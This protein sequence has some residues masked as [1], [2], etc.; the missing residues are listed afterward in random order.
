MRE[1]KVAWSDL[2]RLLAYKASLLGPGLSKPCSHIPCSSCLGTDLTGIRSLGRGACS[3]DFSFLSRSGGVELFF[4]DLFFFF[5]CS[6]HRSRR[7]STT[8]L[9]SFSLSFS[10]SKSL[11]DGAG[12]QKETKPQGL[13]SFLLRQIAIHGWLSATPFPHGGKMSC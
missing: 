7:Q 8:L 13:I 2:G 11:T 6:V 10:L 3:V 12:P 1:L 4:H 5:F 9:A